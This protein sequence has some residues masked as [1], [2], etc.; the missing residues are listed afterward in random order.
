[1]PGQST[2]L[3]TSR[4]ASTSIVA[5]TAFFLIGIAAAAN[6]AVAG[7]DAVPKPVNGI[8]LQ[9]EVSLNGQATNLVGTFVMS[10]DT[11]LSAQRS[12][13]N[14]LGLTAPGDDLA[15][16][17]VLRS[18]PG[19]TYHYDEGA[20][21][22][23]IQAS[24]EARVVRT[25]NARGEG[26][27]VVLPK[28]DFGMAL[29]Y[30][31]FASSQSQVDRLSSIGFS[32]ANVS[33]D[34]RIFGP[35]GT[36]N[37][38][39]ILGTTTLKDYDALRLDS[40]WNYSDP[41]SELTYRAGDVISGGLAWTRPIR[42]GGAQVQR[43]F[44]LRPDLVTVAL[45]KFSGS[46]ALPSTVDVYVN[47]LKSYSQQVGSGPFEIS[48]LPVVN[49]GG[50]ARVVLQDAQGRQTTSELPFFVSPRLLKEGLIDFSV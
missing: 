48:N 16:Y 27:A 4:S 6:N 42:L 28:T 31:F 40:T 45:P 19:V 49:S 32:G 2:P 39:A 44:S 12:E 23:E 8:P 36:F 22:I 38:S 17:V 37:Q 24:D 9:L 30:D 25:Y 18:L 33:L 20:Q 35:M 43:N 10:K 14:E 29:N 41:E 5:A 50:A 7:A 47:N 46:A 3:R 21:K 15:G 34:A 1:M 11:G 26:Q 13:L